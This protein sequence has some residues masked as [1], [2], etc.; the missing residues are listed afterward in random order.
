MKFYLQKAYFSIIVFSQTIVSLLSTLLFSSYRAGRLFSKCAEKYKKSNECIVMGNGPSIT[1][2]FEEKHGELSNKDIFAVNY[3]CLTGYFQLVK[4]NFYVLLDSNIFADN[5]SENG[6]KQ[7]EELIA[8]F[9]EITWEMVLFV[10]EKFKNRRLVTSFL[11]EHVIVVPFNSTPVNG[12]KS[13]ENFLY[14]N[15]LG[16]PVPQTVINAVIFLAIN[17]KYDEIH[18]YGVEQSWLKHLHVTNDNQV[19]VSLPHF[20]AGP[21]SLGRH[22]TLRTLSAFLITQAACFS[23]H[24]RLQEYAKYKGNRILNHTPGSYIDAYERVIHEKHDE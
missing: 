19:S 20:Y 16:M 6:N 18:L 17:M 10:P 24:M 15:N 23:S 22:S 21:D 4:P 13:V 9:N 8:T 12:I 7:T 11:N 14:R 1:S 5:L 3:F 2:L